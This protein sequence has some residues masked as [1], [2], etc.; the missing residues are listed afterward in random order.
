MA[1]KY[2][3]D[4]LV[5][6]KVKASAEYRSMKRELSKLESRRKKLHKEHSYSKEIKAEKREVRNAIS[7]LNKDLNNLR[8]VIVNEIIGGAQIILST[9]TGAL[10]RVLTNWMKEGPEAKSTKYGNEDKLFDVAILD[11]A[12]Q[13]MEVSSWVLILMAKKAILAGDHKQLPP[14]VKSKEAEKKGLGNTLFDRLAKLCD[15]ECTI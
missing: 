3:L 8:R 4:Y 1:Q 7:N 10:D 5:G 6:I 15:L 11:E 14:T 9:Q 13:S 12:A 2:S